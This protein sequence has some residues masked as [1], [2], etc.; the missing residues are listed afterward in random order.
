MAKRKSAV[1]DDAEELSARSKRSRRVTED[2]SDAEGDEEED[3]MNEEDEE[4]REFEA[5]YSERVL[6]SVR[7]S[8]RG[9][10]VSVLASV[11]EKR[12]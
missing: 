10:G 11:E 3:E 9:A 5:K 12:R 6:E 8:Q 7:N 4:E 2:I 1:E